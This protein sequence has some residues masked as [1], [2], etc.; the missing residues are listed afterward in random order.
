M[1]TFVSFEGKCPAIGDGILVLDIDGT[2]WEFSRFAL[3]P[4]GETWTDA[5]G[6]EHEEYSSWDVGIW[7]KGFPDDQK[8]EAL[9]VI[10]ENVPPAVITRSYY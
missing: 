1:V 4:V 9:D 6:A 3:V 10:N 2:R 7:P 5:Y 8:E